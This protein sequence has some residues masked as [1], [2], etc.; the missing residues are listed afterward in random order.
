MKVDP[1]AE[2]LGR[3]AVVAALS[4][5]R[6]RFSSA[7]DAIAAADPRVS[8]Q[9]IPIYAAVAQAALLA[10][11]NGQLPNV[12]Q[13][14]E[15]AAEVVDS[16]NW[17]D[18]STDSVYEVLASLCDNHVPRIDP[19]QA[20]VILFIATAYMISSYRKSLGFDSFYKALDSL[21]ESIE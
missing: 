17:A 1:K 9:I 14:R 18:I 15:M 11:H 21:L 5:E 20:V 6:D 7:L 19:G 10:I 3:S 8:Q 4:R 2:F 16:E 13:V 12:D